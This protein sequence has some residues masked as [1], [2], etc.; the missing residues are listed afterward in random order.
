MCGRRAVGRRGRRLE[1]RPHQ[2][3]PV[4]RALAMLERA[5]AYWNRERCALV[6][7][8]G[9]LIDG[10]NARSGASARALDAALSALARCETTACA[11]RRRVGGVVHLIGNHELYNF[12]RAEL[13]ARLHNGARARARR[14]LQP[15]ARAGLARPRP[16]P[17]PR[18][19]HRLA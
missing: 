4:L 8:L 16:R 13:A 9:D 12:D 3:A 14:V 15:R 2:S 6:A 10:Q 19:R 1:L 7:Q 5:V 17:V 11:R 18:C